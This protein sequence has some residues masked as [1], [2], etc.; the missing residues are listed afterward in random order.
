ADKV[1]LRKLPAS[2]VHRFE[3]ELRVVHTASKLHVHHDQLLQAEAYSSQIDL[4][5]SKLRDEVGVADLDSRRRCMRQ[6]TLA[7]DRLQ[8]VLV[9][10]GQDQ[11]EIAVAFVERV[12]EVQA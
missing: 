1:C 2:G 10:L 11:L 7:K 3:D 6:R 9:S 5:I 12:C 8:G 4:G